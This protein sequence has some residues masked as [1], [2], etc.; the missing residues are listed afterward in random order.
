MLQG[1]NLREYRKYQKK[2]KVKLVKKWIK[3][4]LNAINYLHNNNYIHHDIK[5]QNILV[6][7]ISGNLKLGD[8][9]SAEELPEQ[10]YFTKYVG[11]EEFM[12]LEVKDGKYNFKADVYSLGLTIIQFITMEKPYKEYKRKDNI[13]NAKKK[14]EYPES[15]ERIKNEEIKNFIS[16]CLKDEKDRPSCEEL[17]NNKWLND[18]D[19]PDNKTYVE[20]I[21][22]LRINNFI[23]GKKKSYFEDIGN[24]IPKNNN[25][26]S[27]SSNS[28]YSQQNSKNLNLKPIYS[29]EISKL[30]SSSKI[31]TINTQVQFNTYK[32][33]DSFEK[34][35]LPRMR[36]YSIGNLS[37]AKSKEIMEL[38]S[39]ESSG[40]KMSKFYKYKNKN[41]IN[42]DILIQA[43]T[44]N[45][46]MS[47]FLYV[48]ENDD[49]IFLEFKEKEKKEENI[50]FKV[51]ILVSNK[52]WKKMKLLEKKME[53]NFDYNGEK[54]NIDLIINNLNNF[55]EL[56]KSD[57]LLIKKKLNGKISKL[58]KEKKMRLLKEKMSHIFK[59]LQYL[60]NNEEFY[61]LESFVNN[62][63]NCI[64]SKFPKEIKDKINFFIEKKETIN[65]F[66][67]LNN[68]NTN[69]DYD[70]NINLICK[71]DIILNLFEIEN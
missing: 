70:N 13:Y 27:F 12:A 3:Q 55:I 57:I 47:L 33:K 41:N 28:L 38:F 26:F 63:N 51:K 39:N 66:F 25:L 62:Q 69:D 64:E 61:I 71:E 48:I 53:M 18:K 60:S 50:L 19:S 6:D 65:N 5:C 46:L 31:K 49:K 36:V 56:N 40:R 15:F 35:S 16:L 10:G 45:H 59:N 2:L 23:L 14:G 22:N 52:K 54:E 42:G 44:I 4:L 17:I 8:L 1:G 43:K 30:N 67:R 68:I 11:T 32:I 29:L 7:R 37:K 34:E 20:I 24:G 9:L 21:N 58:I